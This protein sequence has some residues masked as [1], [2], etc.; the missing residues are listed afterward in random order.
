[1]KRNGAVEE[2]GRTMKM[3][4]IREIINN[5]TAPPSIQ[6]RSHFTVK[7]PTKANVTQKEITVTVPPINFVFYQILYY[8]FYYKGGL[9]RHCG[10]SRLYHTRPQPPGGFHDT[11]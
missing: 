9:F 4:K 2:E 6:N 5:G 3:Q 1:M 7:I 10:S 8:N 11:Y